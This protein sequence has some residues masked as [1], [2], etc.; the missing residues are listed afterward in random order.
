MESVLTITPHRSAHKGHGAERCP[1][2]GA[3]LMLLRAPRAARLHCPAEW[4]HAALRVRGGQI[5]MAA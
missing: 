1:R 4:C 2:C 5:E 3:A